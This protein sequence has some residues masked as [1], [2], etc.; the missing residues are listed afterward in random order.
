MNKLIRH[1]LVPDHISFLGIV[2]FIVVGLITKGWIW[3][4][5]AFLLWIFSFLWD[6]GEEKIRRLKEIERRFKK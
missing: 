1:F 3:I 5:I 2:A 4:R 6:I